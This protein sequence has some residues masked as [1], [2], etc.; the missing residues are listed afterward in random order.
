MKLWIGSAV[1][2]V[3][4]LVGCTLTKSDLRRQQGSE[5]VPTVGGAGQLSLPKQCAIKLVILARPPTDTTLH[6]TL[7]RDAD[8]QSVGDEARSVLEANGIRAGVVTGDLPSEVRSILEAPPPNQIDPTMIVRPDGDASDIELATASA[9]L[10][11]LLNRNGAVSGKRY[12][13]AKGRIKLYA[14]RAGEEGVT[15][16][17]VPEV[18]H[19]PIRQGWGPAPGGGAFAPQ[20]LVMRNGQEEEAL[21]DLAATVT[22]HAGQVLLLSAQ[23]DMSSSLG[24]FLFTDHEPN[25]DRPLRKVVF[26]WATRSEDAPARPNLTPT[27]PPADAPPRRASART[28]SAP[29]A[30]KE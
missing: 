20:Q 14:S 3:L 26:I 11:L 27:E 23:A 7:W 8:P 6:E 28:G 30:S 29:E 12:K 15:V 4:T 17:V 24:N 16:R 13:E 22:L 5:L 21:R 9:D 18:L 19:G 10:D 25:S 1:L 2:G